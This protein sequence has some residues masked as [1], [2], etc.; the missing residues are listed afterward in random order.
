[1]N[2]PACRGG[3]ILS[4]QAHPVPVRI[5]GL[6]EVLGPVVD[7]NASLI[8]LE[9]P[10]SPMTA[11]SLAQIQLNRYHHSDAPGPGLKG[12]NV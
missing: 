9:A 8:I 6:E 12:G 3:A 1:M 11:S 7:P 4:K 2:D 10:A 5:L